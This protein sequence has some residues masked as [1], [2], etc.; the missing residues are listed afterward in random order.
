M[1]NHIEGMSKYRAQYALC[2]MMESLLLKYKSQFGE[3]DKAA[4][5][6]EMYSIRHFIKEK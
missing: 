5:L 1:N 3:C 6:M 4:T 2:Q